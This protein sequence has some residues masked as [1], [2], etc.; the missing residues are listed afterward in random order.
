MIATEND[1][2]QESF[3]QFQTE[4]SATAPAWLTELRQAAMTRFTELGIPTKRI[5]DWR[6][7]NVKSL[8][9][10]PYQ[11]VQSISL[12]S[13]DAEELL[14]RAKLDDSFHRLV[15][16]N[17]HYV[18]QW[19]TQH[20]LPEGVVIE[21]L[22]SSI[23]ENSGD[24]QER[25]SLETSDEA[26]AFIALNTAFVNDGALID[27]PEGVVL[28]RPIHLIFLSVESGQTVCHPRN[29]IRLGKGSRAA[30]IESYLGREGEGYFTNA[31]TQ[32]ELDKSADLDHH[33]LQHEQTDSLHVASTHIDQKDSSEFRSHYFSFGSLMARNEINCM[34]DGGEIVA[35]LNGLYM[36]TGEQLM[37]CRTRIDHAKPNCNT[38]ELYKGIL[39]DHAKGVFNGKIFVHQ[40]AQKTDAKQSN[41]ALLLS[42]DAVVNTKPQLEIYADDVK[43]THGA[44]IGELDENALYYLRS[45]GVSKDLARKMLIFAFANDVVQGVEIPAVRQHLETIL[46]SSHGLPDV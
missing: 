12:A 4:Q 24:L 27:I 43:C 15:F 16:V 22:A 26:A 38:Y 44:T 20:E 37:D 19:S 17:G 23:R 2:Y 45:R 5:E 9:A 41:Q 13:G 33:K 32:I 42:D 8:A 39:D 30:V 1:A 25:L 11:N 3:N 40:D 35:T 10:K 14:Q 29:L 46:L 18:S 6:F 28:D 7:T 21:N 34:L 36:P 31:I